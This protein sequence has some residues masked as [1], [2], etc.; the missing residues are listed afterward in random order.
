MTFDLFAPTRVISGKDCVV[1]NAARFAELGTK[2]LIITDKIAAVKSGALADVEK[3]LDSQGI[4]HKLF[5]EVPQ[6]PLMS[7]CE[8]AAA[9]AKEFGADFL[10]GIGG[11]SCMDAT[12]ATAFY[13]TNPIHGAEIYS[14]RAI[15][16]LPIALIGTTAGTGSEITAYAV[17]TNDET[18]FKGAYSDLRSNARYAFGDPKYT[19]TLPYNFTVST[20]MDAIAHAVE[21]YFCANAE[22]LGDLFALRAVELIL[23]TLLEYEAD[24]ETPLSYEQREKLYYGSLYAGYP[25]SRAGTCF[26]HNMGYF[27]TENY[28]VP[29]GY[30]CAIFLPALMEDAKAALPEKVARLLKFVDMSYDEFVA[31]LKKLT[32]FDVP[33]LTDEEIAKYLAKPGVD[34]DFSVSPNGFDMARANKIMHELFQ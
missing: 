33:K 24:R 17:L 20:A 14:N 29:H 25:L 7:T 12:K 21:G 28:R 22:E 11:G 27:L 9:I 4:A 13:I 26:C 5:D 19:M 3:A 32:V 23:P 34:A 10:I 2:C 30:A 18:H 1:N 8:T 31:A 16:P 15:D 6:N